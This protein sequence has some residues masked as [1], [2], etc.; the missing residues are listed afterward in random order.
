[1][2]IRYPLIATRYSPTLPILVHLSYVV[3]PTSTPKSVAKLKRV[4]VDKA[5]VIICSRTT[6][7]GGKEER[8]HFIIEEIRREEIKLWDEHIEATPTRSS[9]R[10][11][12][13]NGRRHLALLPGTE[14]HD[15]KLAFD[16]QSLGLSPSG[17]PL[18]AIRDVP[19]S[20][21][22]PNIEREVRRFDF[23]ARCWN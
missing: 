17:L 3:P 12:V 23:P 8:P 21:R 19:L 7:R 18:I 1:M 6:T 14:G 13:E 11:E 20:V 9:Q 22:T 4:L 10:G 2:S 15:L 5:V 16:L